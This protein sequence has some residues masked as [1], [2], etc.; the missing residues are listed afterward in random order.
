[1]IP[2]NL[3]RRALDHIWRWEDLSDQRLD[4]GRHWRASSNSPDALARLGNEVRT[5]H[6]YFGGRSSP[7][8]Q[9]VTFSVFMGSGPSDADGAPGQYRAAL[10]RATKLGWL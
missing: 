1:L 9:P 6:A 4:Q 10:E 7:F 3:P 8:N 5:E 2:I